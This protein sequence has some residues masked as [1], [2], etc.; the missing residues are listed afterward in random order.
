M[1]RSAPYLLPL[2]PLGAGVS[3]TA[4]HLGFV[5]FRLARCDMA[6]CVAA[7]LVPLVVRGLPWPRDLRM[8]RV[9]PMTQV[10]ES[11]DGVDQNHRVDQD[12]GR[13]S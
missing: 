8:D 11:T 13:P 4:E 3:G 6:S 12:H 7:R 2:T 1:T 5:R 9:G 10:F